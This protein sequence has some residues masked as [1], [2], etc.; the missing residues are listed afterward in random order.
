MVRRGEY[1]ERATVIAGEAGPLEGLYHRGSRRPPVLIAPEHPDLASM[2][3]PIVAELAWALT[4]AGHPTLR[5]NYRGVGASRGPRVATLDE[6]VSDARAARRHLL[7]PAGA[8]EGEEPSEVESLPPGAHV[9]VGVGF[10]ARVAAV[11]AL[12]DT[13]ARRSPPDPIV[14]V[15]PDPASLPVE[16]PSL[17]VEVVLVLPA[18]GVDPEPGR[19]LAGRLRAGRLVTIPGSDPTFLRGL[20]ELGRVVAE[21]LSPPGMIDLG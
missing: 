14:L 16:L 7:V 18:R 1:L 6:A 20:V 15:R 12:E 3:S 21:A 11:L 8:G 10:G 9:L 2:E 19:R 4:R 13:A 17:A 5:F